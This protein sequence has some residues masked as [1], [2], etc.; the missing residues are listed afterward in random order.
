MFPSPAVLGAELPQQVAVRALGQ[1]SAV[2]GWGWLVSAPVVVLLGPGQFD[3]PRFVLVLLAMAAAAG[4]ITVVVV[5]RPA[6]LP[7]MTAAGILVVAVA[8]AVFDSWMPQ[9]GMPS[10]PAVSLVGVTAL[11]SGLILRF[12]PGIAVAF[13]LA[14]WHA[15]WDGGLPSGAVVVHLEA[16]LIAATSFAGARFVSTSLLRSAGQ[17]ADLVARLMAERG[18]ERERRNRES[19]LTA[20]RTDVHDTVLTTLSGIGA[21]WLLTAGP[22]ALRDELR[23]DV[24]MLAD[25]D[26]PATDGVADLAEVLRTMTRTGRFGGLEVRVDAPVPVPVPSVVADAMSLAARE[27]LVNVVK[28]AGT[29]SAVVRL[30]Q[31][32]VELV[33]TVRDAGCGFTPEENG[34]GLGLPGLVARMA[35]VGGRATVASRPGEGT[36]V[37]LRRPVNAQAQV[38]PMPPLWS[39]EGP[40]R[41]ALG[42]TLVGAAAVS[43][44]FSIQASNYADITPQVLSL[45]I[46][47]LSDALLIAV[48][49]RHRTLPGW[50]SGLLIVRIALA[51]LLT[52]LPLPG[53]ESMGFEHFSGGGEFLVCLAI[54]LLRPRWEALTALAVFSFSFFVLAVPLYAA[55]ESCGVTAV[56]NTAIGLGLVVAGLAF[57]Q[58][59]RRHARIAAEV[60]AAEESLAAARGASDVRA[61]ERRRLLPV[62]RGIVTETLTGLA[63][64]RLDP[65]DADVRRRCRRDARLVRSFLNQAGEA[66][67]LVTDFFARSMALRA[68][69]IDLAI[70]GTL[71]RETVPADQ[72]RALVAGLDD[73][74]RLVGGRGWTGEGWITFLRTDDG[75]LVTLVLH[76]LPPGID[77]DDVRVA[78]LRHGVPG[79]SLDRAE[80]TDGELWLTCRLATSSVPQPSGA[81]A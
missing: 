12:R 41:G 67:E 19:S 32:A 35:E 22:A 50:L 75:V 66:D 47:L 46:I 28:H 34:P 36:T 73:C 25:L 20:A 42:I 9:P 40:R 79:L 23:S 48:L 56:Q 61:A 10:N 57:V 17:V 26:E 44:S 71:P 7:A 55:G 30:R 31:D 62:V 6:A 15:W 81:P 13:G 51:V 4:V 68:T 14:L 39:V 3:V 24:R 38:A 59:I 16:L 8:I 77:A 49:I 78:L 52:G 69:G 64:G 5:R 74:I 58:A 60:L 18:A 76:D 80:Q 63:E 37:T 1:A 27:A 29:S 21:G 65:A 2:I 70:R 53:C 72:R 45:L 43:L 54:T 33:V 11:I